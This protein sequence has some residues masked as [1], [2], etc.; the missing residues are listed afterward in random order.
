MKQTETQEIFKLIV[1]YYPNF[2]HSKQMF[3]AWHNIL[4]DSE[5]ADIKANLEAYV[6]SNKFPPV[7]SDLIDN[8]PTEG[9]SIPTVEETKHMLDKREAERPKEPVDHT[10]VEGYEKFIEMLKKGR[11]DR[12]G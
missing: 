4:K 11:K 10:K 6:K 5:F 8:A 12:H 2:K 1:I 7:I 9:R 3:D